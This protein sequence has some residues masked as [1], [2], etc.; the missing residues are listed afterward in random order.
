MF[1]LFSRHIQLA[2]LFAAPA[3]VGEGLELEETEYRRDER[4]AG[5]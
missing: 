3:E 5:K 1:F 2:R 4:Q